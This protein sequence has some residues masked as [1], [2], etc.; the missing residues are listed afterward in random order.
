MAE[1]AATPCSPTDP[2]LP[3]CGARTRSGASCR[4]PAGFGTPNPGRGRCRAH[5]GMAPQVLARYE[6]EDL[7]AEAESFGVEL[8]EVDPGEALLVAVAAAAA[9]LRWVHERSTGVRVPAE[10]V[11]SPEVLEL[12]RLERQT[13]D[14]LVGE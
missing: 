10:R 13:L 6:R 14:M 12:A 11:T 9:R 1:Q 7:L 5:G 2:M 4:R 3:L 8:H